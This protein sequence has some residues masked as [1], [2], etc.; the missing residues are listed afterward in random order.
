[1]KTPAQF[2]HPISIVLLQVVGGHFRDIGLLPNGDNDE[3][4]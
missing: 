4:S 2:F 3:A 1:M